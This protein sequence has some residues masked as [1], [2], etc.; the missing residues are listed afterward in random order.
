MINDASSD[1]DHDNDAPEAPRHS[2]DQT[3]QQTALMN[4]SRTEKA[5]CRSDDSVLGRYDRIFGDFWTSEMLG[6]VISIGTIVS[7]V[8]ILFNFQNGSTNH[9][10]KG[11]TVIYMY[12]LHVSSDIVIAQ[13]SN[14]HTCKSFSSCNRFCHSLCHQ[15]AEMVSIRK[16][17][18]K[19]L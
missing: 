11:V 5:S 6:V 18:S 12:E 13:H 7:I 14:I 2:R 17:A 3:T 19:S 15:S 4:E 1:Q 16:E 8:S 9:L 10:M